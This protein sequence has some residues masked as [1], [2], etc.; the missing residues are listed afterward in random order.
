MAEYQNAGY[1]ASNL[2]FKIILGTVIGAV[3]L[4]ISAVAWN[5]S[6]IAAI[7]TYEEC[8]AKYEVMDSYPQQCRTPDGRFFTE[9]PA[10][11]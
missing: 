3:I 4:I 11:R 7:D 5:I 8:A 9:E 1:K 10:R 2:A 6:Q